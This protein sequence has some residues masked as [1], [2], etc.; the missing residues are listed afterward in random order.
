LQFASEFEQ[1]VQFVVFDEIVGHIQVHELG[2]RDV[3]ALVIGLIF[4]HVIQLG[5]ISELHCQYG[6]HELHETHV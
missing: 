4:A 5:V 3:L 1:L 6:L 2:G